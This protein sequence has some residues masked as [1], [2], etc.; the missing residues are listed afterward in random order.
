MAF[1]NWTEQ[2]VNFIVFAIL[3][4]IVGA[5]ALGTVAMAFVFILLGEVLVRESVSEGLISAGTAT[6][7]DRNVAFW[8]LAVLGIAMMGLLWGAAGRIAAL[9]GVAA[10]A[11]LVRALAPTIPLLAVTAVPVAILRREMRFRV[12]SIRAVLG[13]LTGG[14]VGVGMAV[15][16]YG[17]WSLIGQRIAQVG[18]NAILAWVTSGWRPG[19]VFSRDAVQRIGRFGGIVVGLRL[20]ESAAYQVP[21]FLIGTILG[22]S[23]LGFFAAALRLVDVLAVIIVTPVIS[24]AQPAFAHSSRIGGAPKD[25]LIPMASLTGFVAF[26][27]FLGLAAIAPDLLVVLFGP[28]W[29]EASVAVRVLAIFGIVLSI[30]RLNQSFCLAMGSAGR[31]T[32]VVWVNVAISSGLVLLLADQGLGGTALAV[33]AASLLLWPLRVLITS[34]IGRIPAHALVEVHFRPFLGSLVMAGA[35]GLVIRWFGFDVPAVSVL[36]GV[37]IGV[38]VYLLFAA[39]FMRERFGAV[40]ELVGRSTRGQA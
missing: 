19:F 13:V 39:L 30:E 31:I 26:P 34:R 14:A 8:S 21:Q 20:A 24:V 23:A 15:S 11:D 17:V 25:L 29:S 22:P 27:A 7:A 2:A 6:D 32:L 4:R 12:L 9:F 38:A 5:E 1:G 40:A 33:T 18:V 10:V 36:S 16:G 35:V 3:A 28:E 37:L